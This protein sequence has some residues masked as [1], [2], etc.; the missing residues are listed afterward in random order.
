[1]SC[2]RLIEAVY[3]DGI[4][5]MVKKILL[6]TL[7]LTLLF[8]ISVSASFLSISNRYRK[9]S[10]NINTTTYLDMD[11]IQLVRSDPP[12][13]VIEGNIFKENYETSWIGKIKV[14][15]FYDY[16]NKIM[17]AKF[18]NGAVYDQNG[19]YLYPEAFNIS[20]KNL[21]EVLKTTIG[22]QIGNICFR[23]LYGIYF[24]E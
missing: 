1:M 3:G 7:L 22:R 21:Q 5:A 10:A 9:V 8:S 18:E 20:R 16:R 23:K 14:K 11:S 6:C 2:G 19:R 17:K 13:Y 24:D 4:I 15:F 12:Y